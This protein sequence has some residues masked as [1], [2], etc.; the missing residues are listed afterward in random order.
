MSGL[1]SVGQS[2]ELLTNL[3]LREIRSR[4]KRT[5]LGNAS[6]GRSSTRSPRC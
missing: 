1:A 3:T 4:Y 6:P 2:R 5:I